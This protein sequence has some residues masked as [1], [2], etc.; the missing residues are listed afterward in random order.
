MDEPIR[1]GIETILVAEDDEMLR[2]LASTVLGEFG[3]T[4]LL[5]KDGDDAVEQ[6]KKN[7]DDI[8][9]II[10]DMIMPGRN[11][12]ETYNAIKAVKPDIP[13]LFASGYTADIIK[14]N[15]AS[16]S[17]FDFIMKPLSPIDLLKKIREILDR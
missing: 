6:F 7:K 14:M 1:G 9:L 4:V 17:Q 8:Q 3:Y 5:A 10:L 2:K 13:A 16:E 11:G 15:T 12:L